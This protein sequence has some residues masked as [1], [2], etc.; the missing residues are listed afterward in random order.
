MRKFI[1]LS[2]VVFFIQAF[3]TC[4]AQNS[5]RQPLLMDANWKFSQTDTIGADNPSFDDSKWRI[6]NLPHDWS[7]ESEFIQNAPT[8]GGGGYLPTGIGWYR[9]HFNLPKSVLSKSV[10]IEFDGVYQNSDMWNNGHHLGHYP[11]GY[12][13]FYYDF[14]PYVKAGEDILA[15]RVDN[16][17]QPNSRWYSGSGIYRHVWLNIANPLHVAQ[18]GTYITTPQVDSSSATVHIKTRLNNRS[19]VSKDALLRSLVVDA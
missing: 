17:L 5:N 18:W 15:V 19:A 13:S 8:G 10:W 6:L 7:I 11:N 14:T 3:N 4:I 9:K 16:S 12:M 2:A 1:L